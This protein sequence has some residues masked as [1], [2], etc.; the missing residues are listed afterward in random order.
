MPPVSN[1]PFTTDD[2]DRL[3]GAAVSAWRTGRDRDWSARAGTLDWSCRRTA[4]HAVDAVLAVA[5]FLAARRQDG[6]PDWWGERTLGRDARPEDLAQG[7]EA[8][9]R[10]LSGIVAAT[11]ADVRA[12]IWRRPLVEVRGPA[13]FA[14]RGAL[15]LI[16]HAHDVSAGLGVPLVPPADAC[17]RLREHTRG[18]PHWSSPGWRPAP[19]TDDPW[20]DLLV[21]S[22]RA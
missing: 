19:I 16:L 22:G 13:D 7:L 6:Y 1:D 21:G 15:E 9:A 18:W 3:A 17:L 2:L 11:P 12:V 5:M 10:L 8:A 20:H 4:D 14:P